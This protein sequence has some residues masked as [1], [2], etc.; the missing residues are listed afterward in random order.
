MRKFSTHL[1]AIL[2]AILFSSQASAFQLCLFDIYGATWNLQVKKGDQVYNAKGTVVLSQGPVWNV[3]GFWNRK[4]KQIEL[5][6]INPNPDGCSPYADSFVN[7]GTADGYIDDNGN[8]VFQAGGNQINY[9][10]G[11]DVGEA[12]WSMTTCGHPLSVD[13]I[14]K[15]QN[16]TN[17]TYKNTNGLMLRVVPNPIVNSGTIEYR[18]RE[19]SKVQVTIYNYMS[20]P[21]KIFANETKAKG[22]YKLI[23][24]ARDESGNIVPPGL[25]KVVA[26]VNGKSFATAMQVFRQ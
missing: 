9:C 5:H 23:W 16:I 19:N 24:D 6:A 1:L 4:T 12:T 22:A 2:I 8:L 3:W 26:T 17:G 15:Q 10:N 21:V 7:Y 18:L 20:R 11:L 25:Y 14:E 13:K